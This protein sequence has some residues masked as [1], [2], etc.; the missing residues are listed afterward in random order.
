MSKNPQNPLKRIMVRRG[1][2]SWQVISR[3]LGV[4]L[5]TTVFVLLDQI[6]DATGSLTP[7]A[8]FV[9]TALILLN[10]LGYTELAASSPRSGGAYTVVRDS[11]A[12]EV[13][14]F[15]TGWAVALSGLGISVILAQ[16]AARYL[17]SLLSSFLTVQL[18]LNWIASVLVLVTIILHNLRSK[19][20]RQRY[21]D[22]TIPVLIGLIGLVGLSLGK[23]TGVSFPTRPGGPDQAIV[24]L[25]AGFVGLEVIT[26]Y[27]QEIRQRIITLPRAL[28]LA[29]LLAAGIGIVISAKLM[30]AV[31]S[32]ASATGQPIL[33]LWAEQVMG[34]AGGTAVLVVGFLV[35]SLSLARTTSMAIRHLF[36]MSRDG[37]WPEWLQK[38]HPRYGIPVRSLIAVAIAVT[39]IVWAPSEYLTRVTSLLYIVTLGFVNMALALKHRGSVVPSTERTRMFE[40]TNQP[41]DVTQS[42][43][44]SNRRFALPFHPWIPALTVAVDLLMLLLWDTPSIALAVVCLTIGIGIYVVYARGRRTE[45]QEGITVFSST[46]DGEKK[47]SAFRVLVPIANPATA[48]GLLRLAGQ[49]ARTENGNVVALQVTVV[50]ETLPLEAGRRRAAH[51]QAVFEQALAFADQAGLPI[52]TMTRSSRSVSQGILETANEAAIDLI[53]MGWQEPTHRRGTSLGPIADAVL[54]DAP[55]HVMVV[56]RIPSQPIQKILVPTAGGPH[57][58]AAARLAGLLADTVDATVSYVY[59][60]SGPATEQQIAETRDRLIQDIRK[61][62][63]D[64]EPN[65]IIQTASNAVE[66]IVEAAKTHDMLLIGVSEENMLD[67]VLFGSVPLQ[68]VSQVSTAT[69]VQGDRGITGVWSRRLLRLVLKTFPR[70]G[71]AEQLELLQ[72]LS[73]A[74][75]PGVN[76]F[77]LIVLSCI[78][79]SLGL[80]QSSP[81]VVIGAMLVAP[82]MSPILA[83]SLGMALGDLRLLRSSF[84]SVFKG[85]TLALILSAFI[86]IATP[87]ATLTPEI[88]ARAHPSLLDLGVAL[89]SGLAGAYAIARKDV[90]AALPGV[91]I[92][93]ALMPPLV[94]VGLGLALGDPRVAGGALLLFVTNIAAISLAG[95]IVFVV[96]GVRPLA[97]G[98]DSRRRLRMRLTASLI[99]LAVIAIPL[100]VV[101]ARTVRDATQENLVR[102]IVSEQM[103]AADAELL[104]LGVERTGKG[105][106]VVA[107][108][109]SEQEFSA[110][111]VEELAAQLRKGVAGP[112]EVEVVILPVIRTSIE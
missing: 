72:S 59:V 110:T 85:I 36:V 112:I 84:E 108:V 1:L 104:T 44:R 73:Q 90:S 53:V 97:W 54:R 38:I 27:Q 89:V 109:Q 102:A 76:F 12:Q 23:P 22:F 42:L 29:P 21:V 37:F 88:L 20:Q 87:T 26:G 92:A 68:V 14:A 99:L 57:A 78:I 5:A 96:L 41:A 10:C 100:G 50:P 40:E 65:L 98:P 47:K 101:T 58:R 11:T 61:S 49:I 9:A 33:A 94:T 91:A 6:I 13:L 43:I 80:L 79:A 107:T 28:L 106:R 3:G 66:G 63:P 83:F 25:L 75:R 18:S 56:R 95:G 39:G 103:G 17:A 8:F 60:Q 30:S 15:I 111:T 48:E 105:L 64:R 82:L 4:I 51:Q 7:T 62:V 24:L 16:G 52:S 46:E 69:L 67:R 70:L 81:A 32:P 74:A 2:S 35:L 34:R 77:V 86:G 19:R 31:E 71:H 45:S 93:A 55:C